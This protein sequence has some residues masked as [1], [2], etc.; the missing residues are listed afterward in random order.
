MSNNPEPI[1]YLN[2]E[3]VPL[4]RALIS[5]HDLGWL[6]GY[7]VFEFLIT[8][9]GLPFYLNSHIS[10][11]FNSAKKIEL[12]L[13]FSKKKL[14]SIVYQTLEKNHFYPEKKIKIVISGGISPDSI[15]DNNVPTVAILIEELNKYPSSYYNNGVSLITYNYQRPNPEAKTLDYLI[16]IKAHKSAIKQNSMEA[17][18]INKKNNIVLECTT[19]NI[20]IVTKKKIITPDSNVLRGITSEIIF[21]LARSKFKV[22]K[23]K[24]SINEL[25][26][27][28]EVFITASNKEVMPVVKIDRQIIGLG[29]VGSVTKNIIKLFQNYTSKWIGNE[30]MK[31]VN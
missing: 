24:V 19:S 1:Y 18:Y 12:N 2:G 17:V 9:N 23:Q 29:K 15:T 20:F 3:F 5:V 10:R 14:A 13:P 22:S 4:S 26:Q 7:G 8:Y 25:F 21:E 6:R 31:V 28:D 11:L 30:D 16:G 27:A